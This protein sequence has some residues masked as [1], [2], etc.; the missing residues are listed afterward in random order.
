[1]TLYSALC[2]VAIS[3][4]LL[5]CVAPKTNQ[6]S[7]LQSQTGQESLFDRAPAQEKE[8]S[9]LNTSR[10]MIRVARAI[11]QQMA[12]VGNIRHHFLTHFAQA[13]GRILSSGNPDFAK[14][15]S[16][17]RTLKRVAFSKNV[18]FM[19]GKEDANT[20]KGYV[21][22]N[23]LA[24]S[25]QEKVNLLRRPAIQGTETEKDQ[26]SVGAMNSDDV[27]SSI[28]FMRFI[29]NRVVDSLIYLTRNQPS[30]QSS[31]EE[32]KHFS[33]LVTV[34]NSYIRAKGNIDILSTIESDPMQVVAR[35]Q[36]LKV[37]ES[38]KSL[39]ELVTK[40]YIAVPD[41]N[42]VNGTAVDMKYITMLKLGP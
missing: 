36:N 41:S 8:L 5:S 17:Y 25:L 11:Q 27:G 9:P 21:R 42:D 33:E 35:F 6:S 2:A 12:D 38:W 19:I 23:Q 10:E 16:L 22:M 1:M 34:R 28:S 24:D 3:F 13:T 20:L 29:S 39:L 30:S 14:I 31:N 7:Y 37:T 40:I 32:K 15:T 18:S 26:K 4:L